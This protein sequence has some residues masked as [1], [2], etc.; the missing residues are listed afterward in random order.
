MQGMMMGV[1]FLA[2]HRKA[3]PLKW[4]GLFLINYSLP[5]ITWLL[6]YAGISKQYPRMPYLPIGFFF[7][8]L[9][10]FYLH[11]RSLIG[12]LS[13]RTVWRNLAPALIDLLLFAVV[14]SLPE[15]VFL[16]QK[17]YLRWFVLVYNLSAEVFNIVYA[18]RLIRLVQQHQQK[19]PNFYADLHQRLL[20][21]IKVT[22]WLLLVLYSVEMVLGYFINRQIQY[23]TLMLADM[24]MSIGCIYWVAISGLRQSSTSV[25]LPVE[26]TEEPAVEPRAEAV[27][28]ATAS[29]STSATS[30]LHPTSTDGPTADENLSLERDYATITEYMAQGAYKN[31]DLTLMT[32]ADQ[33]AMSYKRVSLLI[34]EKSGLNFS[35][36]VNQYRVAEAK[37]LLLDAAYHHLSHN[38]IGQASGFRATSTFYQVFRKLTSITPSQ[39]KKNA[40][41]DAAALVEETS[42]ES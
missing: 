30:N 25:V 38:G 23:D 4:L 5:F 7:A 36:F 24:I 40:L 37:R 31:P 28:V 42:P 2:L 14:V 6:D 9:P 33:V 13:P 15:P 26:E 3:R 35:N 34:N 21:W 39:F 12:P 22:A 11:A 41:P 8:V 16:K 1:V 17:Y 10:L 32:L 20:G 19:V 29:E 27:L 18:L